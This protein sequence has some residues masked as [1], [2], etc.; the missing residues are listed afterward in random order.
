MLVEL[1]CYQ[2]EVKTTRQSFL[3]FD[4]IS[5]VGQSESQV[6]PQY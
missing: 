4:D 6:M 1:D 2:P 5:E 3:A